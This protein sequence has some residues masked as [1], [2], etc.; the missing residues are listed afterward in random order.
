MS[1]SRVIGVLGT[2]ATVRQPYVDDLAATIRRRLHGHPPRLARAGRAGRGQARGEE[3]SVEAVRAAAQPMFD[4]ARAASGST[5]SSSPAPISRCSRTSLRAA[6]PGVAYVDGG[7]GHRPPHRLSDPR[8]S[9]GRPSPSDGLMRCSPAAGAA[10]SLERRSPGSGSAKSR[11]CERADCKSFAM[12][13][14]RSRELKGAR[15]EELS[16]GLRPHLQIGDRAPSRRGPLPRVHRYPAHQGQLPQRALL[17]RQRP[18]ADHRLVLERLS[19]H[20]PAPGRGRGDGSR[21]CTT[22]APARAAPATSAATPIIIS[23]SRPSL[24]TSTARKAALLF[25]SGYVSNEAALSTLGKL[26]PGCVIF[27]DELNHASMIAGIKNSRLRE[28]RVPPQR[29]RP[30]RGAARRRG[31]R[32]RPS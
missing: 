30:S 12:A 7:A 18:E 21:R 11:P 19:R 20:G 5:R 9:R 25:T 15:S 1:K 2:E 6:F 31:S 10:P 17:R 26:L 3:V 29:P 23:S 22:S 32:R 14:A 4:A 24:P 27:S 16:L 28:A 13:F 8:A